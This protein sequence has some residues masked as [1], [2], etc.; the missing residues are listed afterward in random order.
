MDTRNKVRCIEVRTNDGKAIFSFQVV[1]KELAG[2]NQ[3]AHPQNQK[4]RD[5]ER[6]GNSNNH[7]TDESL[8]TDAQK[9][10]LFRLLAEQ[11]IE[12][13]KA[14]EYL[15]DSFQ[16]SYLKEASKFDACKMIERLLEENKGGEQ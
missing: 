11:G 12:G 9:R 14:H 10:Y 16:V 3:T 6:K 2:E 5:N 8:M 4:K 1:E 7:Q 13:D 15:K